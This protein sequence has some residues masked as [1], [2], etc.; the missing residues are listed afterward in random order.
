MRAPAPAP[1][2][3]REAELRRGEGNVS[4]D[5]LSQATA[6]L[7]AGRR[8]LAQAASSQRL[9]ASQGKVI[10]GQPAQ[11]SFTQKLHRFRDL[12]SCAHASG[13]LLS[14]A[15]QNNPVLAVPQPNVLAS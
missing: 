5:T 9:A 15:P 12:L 2:S 11:D 1:S 8:H 4:R 6:G 3:M 10:C 7:G 13:G 14:C